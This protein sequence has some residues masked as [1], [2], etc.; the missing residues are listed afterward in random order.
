MSVLR[1]SLGRTRLAGWLAGWC[2]FVGQSA[3]GAALLRREEQEEAA[4]ERQGAA[5][6]ERA[7]QK[8]TDR[9]AD[10]AED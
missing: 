10:R 5:W 8:K 6:G 4:P 7:E 3:A 2:Q 9:Q 1:V